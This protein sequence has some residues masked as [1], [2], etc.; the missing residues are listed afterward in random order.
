MS[1][2]ATIYPTPQRDAQN[3][4]NNVDRGGGDAGNQMDVP[5]NAADATEV[6]HT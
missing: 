1:R 3:N 4:N 6:G 2:T 5:D